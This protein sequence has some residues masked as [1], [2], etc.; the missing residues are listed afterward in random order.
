MNVSEVLDIDGSVE[1]SKKLVAGDKIT[2]QG[3][4]IKNVDEVGAEVAEIST[5]EGLR[6]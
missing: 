5:T 6:H 1:R 3:F 2:I 4:K